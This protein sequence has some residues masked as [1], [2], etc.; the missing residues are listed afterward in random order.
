MG[1]QSVGGG[2]EATSALVHRVNP[3]EG[4]EWVLIIDWFRVQE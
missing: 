2:G 3:V 4:A 1:G